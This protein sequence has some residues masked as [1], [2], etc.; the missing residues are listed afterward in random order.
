MYRTNI[1]YV[2]CFCLFF[3][4]ATSACTYDNILLPETHARSRARRVPRHPFVL[5]F[6]FFH[7]FNRPFGYYHCYYLRSFYV[8]VILL[9]SFVLGPLL[10]HN[11][12][13]VHRGIYSCFFT[14]DR[15]TPGR[16]RFSTRK[17]FYVVF[18]V[19]TAEHG[20]FKPVAY[21]W[22]KV[23]TGGTKL[24]LVPDS[25]QPQD[26][27][28]NQGKRRSIGPLSPKMVQPKLREC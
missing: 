5:F 4:C 20:R 2:Y 1:V 24:N 11:T 16:K 26:Q 6:Y 14:L 12:I 21:T 3:F 17:R 23:R 22:V 25:P 19:S 28:R 15:F 18:R 27:T 9:P 7:S 13:R 8:V 10:L